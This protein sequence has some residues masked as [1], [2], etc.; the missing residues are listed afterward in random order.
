MIKEFYYGSAWHW[1][2]QHIP[3]VMLSYNFI[4]SL[5]NPWKIDIPFMLDS[6]AYSVILKYGKYPYS[7]EEYAKA[8]EIWK[9]DIA[10]TMD[11]PC[12]PSVQAKGEY[13]PWKAQ[14]MTIQNQIKLQDLGVKTSMVVQ[15]WDINDYLENLDIIK[16]YGLLT[17]RLGIGSICRRNKEKEIARI[18]RAIHNNVPRWVKL[19][20]FGIKVSVLQKTDARYFLFSADSSAWAYQWNFRHV[21]KI[22]NNRNFQIKDKVDGLY[23]YMNK[24]E[25]ILLE[26]KDTIEKWIIE[27]ARA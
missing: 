20:A 15:G 8:I 9:P 10:W 14:E 25:N 1:P 26:K 2:L 6:G 18:I 23:Q 24:I 4:R 7:I 17:E 11:Y 13:T 19:H 27:E 12:E 3:R 21:E 16:E 5:K 22:R